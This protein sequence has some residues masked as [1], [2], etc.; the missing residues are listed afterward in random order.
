MTLLDTSRESITPINNVE[1]DNNNTTI[2]TYT[3]GYMINDA[4]TDISITLHYNTIHIIITQNNTIGGTILQCD[5]EYLSL[6][7]SGGINYN[8][9]NKIYFNIKVLLGNRNKSNTEQILGRQLIE[10]IHNYNPQYTQI[11]LMISLKHDKTKQ[12]TKNNNT[13]VDGYSIDNIDTSMI[14]TL[15]D[16]IIESDIIQSIIINR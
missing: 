13:D 9:N 6:D 3:T 16:I 4:H 1:T 10:H 12:T 15:F 5:T 8:D 2:N 14:K 7:N 11:I